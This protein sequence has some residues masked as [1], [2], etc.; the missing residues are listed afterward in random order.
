[1]R[2]DNPGT[3]L[4]HC[5][6]ADHMMAGMYATYTV[7]PRGGV[8]TARRY[9]AA[10]LP[11]DL[12]EERANRVLPFIVAM[13]GGDDHRVDRVELRDRVG[14]ARAREPWRLGI[15]CVVLVGDRSK[16]GPV[17]ASKLGPMRTLTIDD[18]LG[19]APV[20]TTSSR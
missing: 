6:V 2:A 13:F 5:H 1:M 12:R 7:A 20:V 15:R 16:I 17:R 14:V 10:P 4:L 19:P 8:L 3:W 18:V 9:S 11:I